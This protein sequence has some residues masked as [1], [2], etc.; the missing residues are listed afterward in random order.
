MPITLSEFNEIEHKVITLMGMSGVGKTY[1]STMLGQ[2][3]W[4][5]SSCDYRIAKALGLGEQVTRQDISALSEY[6][7]RLG[8]PEKG[9]LPLEE[10][11]ARQQAYFKAECEALAGLKDRV[12]QAHD[13]GFTHVVNDSTG[14]MC[15]IDDDILLDTVDEN[16]LIVYIKAS[17][18]EEQAVLERAKMNPKP[19]FYSPER[20]EYWL[21]EY[22]AESGAATAD[23]IEPDDFSRW[24][25]PRLFENRL[26]KY[27]AIADKY[28]T[29]VPSSAF[30]GVET[31]DGFLRII[32]EHLDE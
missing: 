18:E 23:Q 8:D 31:A 13:E 3:G 14:S 28:G 5:H 25:F 1:L 11:R 16:S 9:G 19:L 7:G 24:V 26:P 27:Q 17:A 22:L 30:R 29:T 15:E 32:A 10:F 21:E 20:F 12:K 6:V 4:C 2:Q